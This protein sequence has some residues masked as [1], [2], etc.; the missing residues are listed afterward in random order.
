MLEEACIFS[1]ITNSDNVGLTEK[2]GPEF[3]NQTCEYIEK[4]D[5]IHAKIDFP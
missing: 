1:N 2:Q 4:T 5:K 3:E